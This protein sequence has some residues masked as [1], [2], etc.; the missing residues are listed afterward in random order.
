MYMGLKI[1]RAC[2]ILRLS[3]YIVYIPVQKQQIE[4]KSTENSKVL[5]FCFRLYNKT[6]ILV[7]SWKTRETNVYYKTIEYIYTVIIELNLIT[8]GCV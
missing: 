6:L 5:H 4:R 8:L 7:L 3:R 2:L 1:G